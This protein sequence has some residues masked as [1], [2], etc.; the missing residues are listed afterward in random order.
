MPLPGLT[1]ALAMRGRA[2]AYGSGSITLTS[3]TSWT[4]PANFDP[5]KNTIECYGGGGGGGMG[6]T[7]AVAPG[8]G[9]GGGGGGAYSSIANLALAP[10]AVI[11]ISIGAAGFSNGGNGG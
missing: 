9:G 4:V 10:G 2:A 8:G 6:A 11:P 5:T 7:A 3:G 1:S